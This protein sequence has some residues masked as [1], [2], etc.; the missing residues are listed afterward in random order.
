MEQIV[1]NSVFGKLINRAIFTEIIPS[2]SGEKLKEYAEQVIERFHN[3][4]LDHKLLSIALNSLSKWKT[5][6]LPSVVD[7]TEKFGKAPEVLSFSF[8]VLY[9]FYKQ[10][11]GVRDDARCMELTNKTTSLREFLKLTE[12]WGEDLSEREMFAEKAEKYEKKI[13][14]KGIKKVVEELASEA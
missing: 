13:C 6:V 8:A 4:F 14:E 10:G 1:T 9:V 11:K 7:Y 3:P 5:R 2:F 12:I